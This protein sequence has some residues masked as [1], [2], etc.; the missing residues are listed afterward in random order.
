LIR[1]FSSAAI[2]AFSARTL[3]SL[4]T[5]SSTVRSSVGIGSVICG[6][7]LIGMGI[8]VIDEVVVADPELIPGPQ[9]HGGQASG[10]D[11]LINKP[12]RHTQMLSHL[13]NRVATNLEQIRAG[14]NKRGH[15]FSK[16]SSKIAS[17]SCFHAS[18]GG[19]RTGF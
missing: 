12:M 6:A 18:G 11:L 8:Q 9:V 2:I 13:T 14:L 3:T 7:P 15:S 16:R 10:M 19:F 17:N 5:A 1:S 4:S